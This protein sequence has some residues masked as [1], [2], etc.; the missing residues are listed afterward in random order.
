METIEAIQAARDRVLEELRAM[1]S[2]RRGTINEQFLTDKR[3]KGAEPVVHGPYYVLSRR[4]GGKTVSRRL[5]PGE[6]LEQ[7]RVDIAEHQRFVNLCTRLEELTE[8]LGELTRQEQNEE[9][10]RRQ[11]SKK[12]R[13]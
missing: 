6:D 8:K 5:K 2:L 1:Q 7:A 11:P 13:S 12:T 10:K 3:K 9:K 4:E